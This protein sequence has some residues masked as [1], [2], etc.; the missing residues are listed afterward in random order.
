VSLTGAGPLGSFRNSGQYKIPSQFNGHDNY[1]GKERAATG[2]I[3]AGSVIDATFSNADMIQL[4][5]SSHTN[6]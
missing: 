4:T 1:R 2:S 5:W 6:S 3:V